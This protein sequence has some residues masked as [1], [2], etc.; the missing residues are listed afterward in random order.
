MLPILAPKSSSRLGYNG[1][2][3]GNSSS[4]TWYPLS[5]AHCK[6][7]YYF[8][9]VFKHWI[10]R[11]SPA[12]ER[13]KPTGIKMW[14][15]NT[16]HWHWPLQYLIVSH[17]DAEV[18]CIFNIDI[19][20]CIPVVGM[21]LVCLLTSR[22]PYLW[23]MAI[24]YYAISARE[25]FSWILNLGRYSFEL[26]APFS[27]QPS[28]RLSKWDDSLRI[29]ESRLSKQSSRSALQLGCINPTSWKNWTDRSQLYSQYKRR[30]A[31][32]NQDSI[33]LISNHGTL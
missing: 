8:W 3:R 25:L 32:D 16:P 30:K 33:D 19:C 13:N 18:W 21:Y 15:A 5:S 20:L 12:W 23:H 4:R 1:P 27:S 29:L 10:Q 2:M 9:H 11:I 7:I 24:P 22:V 26:R 28:F 6:W 14:H 31:S 17:D